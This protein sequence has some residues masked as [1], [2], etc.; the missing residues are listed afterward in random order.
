[1]TGGP[2]PGAP[3]DSGLNS[4]IPGQKPP[5]PALSEGPPRR[6]YEFVVM[7]VWREPGADVKTPADLLSGA[8]AAGAGGIVP[9]PGSMTGPMR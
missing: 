8:P 2:A 5:A 9:G 3:K 7:F 4:G 1:M 6:R